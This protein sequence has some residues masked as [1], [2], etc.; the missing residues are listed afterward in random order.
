MLFTLSVWF[1]RKEHFAGEIQL[2]LRREAEIPN[3]KA[4]VTNCCVSLCSFS[5]PFTETLQPASRHLL[6]RW[7]RRQLEIFRSFCWNLTALSIIGQ[8]ILAKLNVPLLS[9]S[10]HHRTRIYT[11]AAIY[12]GEMLNLPCDY[13]M[14]RCWNT[15]INCGHKKGAFQVIKV[16]SLQPL[17]FTVHYTCSEVAV[18]IYRYFYRGG[19][20]CLASSVQSGA[21]LIG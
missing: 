14:C 2:Q 11:Q 4:H 10:L 21:A 20:S 18:F 15:L 16:L 12:G 6:T 7:W 3:T 1:K 5:S 8:V 9:V 19:L 17:K 13:E